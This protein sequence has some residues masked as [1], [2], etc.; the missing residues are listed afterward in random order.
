M[1]FKKVTKEEFFRF[2]DS[3]P[4]LQHLKSG[5]TTIC[6]PPIKHYHDDSLPSKNQLGS[7]KYF[8]DTEVARIIMM[9]AD[10]EYYTKDLRNTEP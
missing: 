3:Y 9:K 8:T 2:I 7:S 10:S 1:D 6:D 5:I 4:S